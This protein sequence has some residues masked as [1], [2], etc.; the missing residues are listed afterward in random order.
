MM[1]WG[2]GSSSGQCLSLADYIRGTSPMDRA[3]AAGGH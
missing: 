1:D 3:D 2:I